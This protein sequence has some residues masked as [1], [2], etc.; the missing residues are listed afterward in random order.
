MFERNIGVKVPEGGDNAETRSSSVIERIHSF[1]YCAFV[2][3][4]R[5]LIYHN[6]R[7]EHC[8]SYTSSTQD[9]TS[10]VYGM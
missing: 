4:T 1:W 6:T 3:V 5:I 9:Y 8:E 7:N 2:C 10:L